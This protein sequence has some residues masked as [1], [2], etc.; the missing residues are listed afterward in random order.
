V[1]VGRDHPLV[2]APGGIHLNVLIDGEQDRESGG[3][4]V[5]GQV[6]TGM[7]VRRA[8]Y[9]GSFLR[10]RRLVE[11]VQSSRRCREEGH[12]DPARTGRARWASEIWDVI[13]LRPYGSPGT[14]PDED[15]GR[16]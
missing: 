15:A 4:L 10:P 1:P 11:A 5:G 12:D 9:S 7:Q 6:G 13:R 8:P 14:W 2:D 3:L 16:L